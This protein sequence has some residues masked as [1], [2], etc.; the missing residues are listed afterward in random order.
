MNPFFFLKIKLISYDIN[1]R[2]DKNENIF[3]GRMKL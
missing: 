1:K 3:L 2:F